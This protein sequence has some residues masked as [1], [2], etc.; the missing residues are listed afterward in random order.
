[1]FGVLSKLLQRGS[2]GREDTDSFVDQ[3]IVFT[4][5]NQP[6]IDS[7]GEGMDQDDKATTEA[8]KSSIINASE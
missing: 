4:Q 2:I 6:E 1:M 3:V 5:H 7:D 8:I